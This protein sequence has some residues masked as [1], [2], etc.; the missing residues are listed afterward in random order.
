MPKTSTPSPSILG[1]VALGADIV[2]LACRHAEEVWA[3]A[4][5]SDFCGDAVSTFEMPASFPEAAALIPSAPLRAAG[6]RIDPDGAQQLVATY[7]VDMHVDNIHGHVLFVILHNDG[8][9]FRQ[10]NV[11]H[12]PVA[13]D[14]F[15]FDDRR[16][17]GV[18][19]VKGKGVM[20]GWSIPVLPL[21]N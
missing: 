19:G 9:R 2:A 16:P 15:V 12:I 1:S 13:G 20:L 8:L 3:D 5:A 11:R 7:D 6:F 10:G 17:H 14:Y 4:V 21:A 18:A